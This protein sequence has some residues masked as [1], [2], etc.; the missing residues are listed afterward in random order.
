MRTVLLAGGIETFLTVRE[1]K[2]LDDHATDTIHKKDLTSREKLIANQM[3][4]KGVLN[5]HVRSGNTFYSLNINK[6]RGD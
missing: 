3:V 4:H 6:R 5:R 2:F 1:G